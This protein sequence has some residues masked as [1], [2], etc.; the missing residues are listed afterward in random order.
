M[1]KEDGVHIYSGV[2]LN[3]LKRNEIGSFAE[4]WMDPESV[5]Q[6]EVSQKEKQKQIYGASRK[7]A[8]MNLFAGQEQRRKCREHTC[9]HSGERRAWDEL[10]DQH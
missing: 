7:M 8:P 6:S 3:H 5:I 4:M 1:D 9:G 10:R 2:L